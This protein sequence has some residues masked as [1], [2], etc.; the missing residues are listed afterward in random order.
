A[1]RV[2]VRSVNP[3]RQAPLRLRVPRRLHGRLPSYF[4]TL[5]RWAAVDFGVLG[6]AREPS[7]NHSYG[8]QPVCKATRFAFTFNDRPEKS[9]KFA[10]F[11]IN[12][13]AGMS[14]C[15]APSHGPP[16]LCGLAPP[17]ASYTDGTG[18]GLPASSH[19]RP[20]RTTGGHA[21][22]AHKG[23]QPVARSTP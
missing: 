1:T 10:S 13:L 16:Q 2:A 21:T 15:A 5:T 12:R 19:Y 9:S 18:A 4:T 22:P 3:N 6:R 11:R 7:E 14:E 23:P 20:A 17:R 8:K